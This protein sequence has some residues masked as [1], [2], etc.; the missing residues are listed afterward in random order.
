MRKLIGTLTMLTMVAGFSTVVFAGGRTIGPRNFEKDSSPPR[1]VKLRP[2]EPAIY[3]RLKKHPTAGASAGLLPPGS[4][5]SSTMAKARDGKN[6]TAIVKLTPGR[7]LVVGE[8]VGIAGVNVEAWGK[9]KQRIRKS[10]RG[11]DSSHVL[12]GAPEG[13]PSSFYRRTSLHQPGTRRSAGYIYD[14]HLEW[15]GYRHVWFD[16]RSKRA[17][18]LVEASTK[19][20]TLVETDN[21]IYL[22]IFNPL[23]KGR[24]SRLPVVTGDAQVIGVSRQEDV[25]AGFSY[26]LLKP[27]KANGTFKLSDP[28]LLYDNYGSTSKSNGVFSYRSLP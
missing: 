9:G 14:Y 18:R 20:P 27:T 4:H 25:F 19:G 10:P 23:F 7:Y 1:T 6:G 24:D 22:T 3:L 21:Y 2:G 15:V 13:F 8:G 16:T 11:S 5:V 17:H 26:L 12:H 28:N